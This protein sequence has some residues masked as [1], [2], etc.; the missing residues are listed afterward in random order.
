MSPV[1]L[2]RRD[3]TLIAHLTDGALIGARKIGTLNL[4]ENKS[5]HCATIA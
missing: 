4:M 3:R 5:P 2:S 1:T